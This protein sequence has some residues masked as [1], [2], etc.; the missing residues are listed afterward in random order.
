MIPDLQFQH[1]VPQFLLR[2]FAHKFEPPVSE[3][4]KG[5]K[6]KRHWK[7]KP[8]LDKGGL[9]KYP[10]DMVV[11]NVNLRAAPYVVDESP[12]SRILGQTNMYRD[13]L[14]PTKEEQNELE[15]MFSK[16]EGQAQRV[17]RRIT[18]AYE[19]G[20]E[21]VSLTRVERDLLR[22]FLFLLKFRGPSFYRRFAPEDVESYS[23]NDRETFQRYMRDKN[24]TR[25]I[26]VWLRSLK[27]VS[28]THLTLPTKA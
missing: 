21:A 5:K 10:G 12:V 4:G 15:T 28:Y 16:M 7:N 14:R 9:K 25:P 2:N 18:K 13:S 27:P 3:N 24:L 23:A 26:E 17:F 6:K 1:F 20:E 19:D 11:N 22:K 8:T